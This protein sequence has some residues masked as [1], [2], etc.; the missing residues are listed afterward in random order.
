MAPHIVVEDISIKSISQAREAFIDGDLRDRLARYHQDVDGAFW[1]WNDIWLDP[2]FRS[3]D[4]RDDC[5]R[6]QAPVLAIQGSDDPYGTLAQID[7]IDLPADQITRIVL[8]DC[9]HSPHRDQV[10]LSTTLITD[11]LAALV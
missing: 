2:A 4:I 11:F 7:G 9:G 1:Q 6:I 5:R 8:P 10:S 3:F